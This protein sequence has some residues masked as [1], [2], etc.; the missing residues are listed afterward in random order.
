MVKYVVLFLL[1]VSLSFSDEFRFEEENLLSQKIESLLGESAYNKKINFINVIFEPKSAF[2]INDRV[3]IIKVVKTLKE[4]GL[5]E[6]FFKVP[7]EL[8]LHFKTSGTPLF[9]VKI[10]SDTLRNIGYYRY[11]TTSSSL[12]ATA[13]EWNIALRA[14]YATDPI[15]L[16]NELKKSGS[17]I[18]DI[19]RKSTDDWTYTIDMS[20]AFLNLEHLQ[21]MEEIKLKHSLYAHWLDC[22]QVDSLSIKSTRRNNWYPYIAFYDA[23]LHLLEVIKKDTKQTRL[24]LNIPTQAKY[25]KISDMYTLKNVKDAL[26]LTPKGTR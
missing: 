24:R 8:H 21:T 11:V 7:Q 15:I 6:L 25:I 19:E 16:Q 1:L 4:N 18:I 17:S 2:Y 23:S 3:N 26:I 13:F 20:R 9:F 14:E 10:M 5:L 12:D 22:S